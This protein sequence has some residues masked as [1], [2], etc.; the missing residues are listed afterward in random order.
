[1]LKNGKE[2]F[3]NSYIDSPDKFS[4]ITP[5]QAFNVQKRVNKVDDNYIDSDSNAIVANG[6]IEAEEDFGAG[7]FSLGFFGQEGATERD[8]STRT[9][10]QLYETFV[11][12]NSYGLVNRALEVISDEATQKDDDNL[13]IQIYTSNEKVNSLLEVLLYEKL[14]LNSEFWNIL[15][16]TIK[17]GD[18]FFEIVLDIEDGVANGIKTLKYLDPS[19]IDIKMKDEKIQ[20]FV[21]KETQSKRNVKLSVEKRFFPWQIAHFKIDSKE[22]KPF[23]RS[24]LYPGIRSFERLTATEDIFLTYAISR[25]PSRRVFRIDVGN[26]SKRQADRAMMNLRD[27]YRAKHIMDENGNLNQLANIMSI[28]SD[29]FIPV[30]EGQSGTQIDVLNGDMNMNSNMGF[31]AG[32]KDDLIRSFNI[33]PE[34]LG[35]TGQQAD[36]SSSLSQ[37]DVKFGRFIER[38]QTQILKTIYKISTL[39]LMINNIPEEEFKEFTITA[40]PPSTIKE[41]SDIALASSRIE[42]FSSMMGTN[43]FPVNYLLKKILKLSDREISELEF[44]KEIEERQQNEAQ[45]MEGMPGG[46]M[47]AGGL[48]GLAPTSGEETFDQEGG[49]MSPEELEAMGQTG[50]DENEIDI[51]DLGGIRDDVSYFRVGGQKILVEDKKDFGTLLKFIKSQKGAKQKDSEFFREMSDAV[52]GRTRTKNAPVNQFYQLREQNEFYGLKIKNNVKNLLVFNNNTKKIKLN[53][54]ILDS[55]NTM[56][57]K[58]VLNG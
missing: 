2:V 57:I 31:L 58:E 51:T 5:Q 44:M 49:E 12:M 14:N 6:N 45:G 10:T 42:L 54:I 55:D 35:E 50:G 56:T 43:V 25:T 20:Y 29:I 18:N 8:R 36:K 41:V 27:N 3:E 28:T 53:K 17:M 26:L 46:E 47:S 9:R 40:T 38:I 19:K 39:E 32:F 7:D 48:S 1:M 24:L 52:L 21:Y 16:E 13:V 15:F 33:P 34:Y 11:K 37:R 30:R 22:T 23:G 4:G